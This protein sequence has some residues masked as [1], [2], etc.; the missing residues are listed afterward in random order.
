MTVSKFDKILPWTGGVAGLLWALWLIIG[1]T[2]DH[3]AA[4]VPWRWSSTRPGETT[5]GA[6]RCWLAA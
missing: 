4:P 5:S 2:P 1:K 6:S 3:P